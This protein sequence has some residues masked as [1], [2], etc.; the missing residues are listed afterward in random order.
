LI[1]LQ[2]SGG[3]KEFCMKFRGIVGIIALVVVIGFGL[4]AC[5]D[6]YDMKVDAP[7]G[8]VATKL[9]DGRIHLTWNSV[10][11]ADSYNIYYRTNM[12][13]QSTKIKD[14]W[15]NVTV[16]DTSKNFSAVE[17]TTVYFY[18]T[19][20]NNGKYVDSDNDGWEDKWIDAYESE[21]SEEVS[22]NIR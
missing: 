8:V 11:R 4:T 14:G 6:P 17:F 16:Y 9:S 3:K 5:E 20:V 18:V 22:V 12:D 21:Y 10:S 2:K 1:S 19:A 7:T 13:S 15:T